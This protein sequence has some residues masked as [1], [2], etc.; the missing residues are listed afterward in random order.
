[1]SYLSCIFTAE[2]TMPRSIAMTVNAERPASCR[3]ARAL[4]KGSASL[5][6]TVTQNS[7]ST[8]EEIAAFPFRSAS[9]MSFRAMPCFPF[10]LT[11]F[12]WTRMLVSKKTC[13]SLMKLV[14]CP[15]H[16]SK[17]SLA[18]PE[19]LVELI[20]QVGSLRLFPLDELSKEGAEEV[21]QVGVSLYRRFRVEAPLGIYMA[22]IA[23]GAVGRGE[24]AVSCGA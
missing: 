2:K 8:W 12:A 7:E 16:P 20:G 23:G 21:G 1:M 22:G 6:V 15:S 4:S 19:K 3:S 14:P 5:L 10:A 24:G 17:G 13:S 9:A 18:L 11:S